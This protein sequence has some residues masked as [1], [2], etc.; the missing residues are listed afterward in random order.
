MEANSKSIQWLCEMPIGI[1]EISG[2]TKQ[3]IRHK[4]AEEIPKKSREGDSSFFICFFFPFGNKI[5]NS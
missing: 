4:V 2:K 3:C 5:M 1:I